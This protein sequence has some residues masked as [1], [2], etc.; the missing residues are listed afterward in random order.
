MVIKHMRLVSGSRRRRGGGISKAIVQMLMEMTGGGC[1]YCFMSVR[2]IQYHVEHITPLSVGG[3][4]AI[5][6]LTISCPDCNK[7]AG[8]KVFSSL[9]AKRN[10]IIRARGIVNGTP[11]FR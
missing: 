1:A 10:Y 4:N 11:E 9:E 8:S 5:G 3:T 7:C 2:G 6:N